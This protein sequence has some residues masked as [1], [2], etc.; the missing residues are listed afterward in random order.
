M[1]LLLLVSS[2]GLLYCSLYVVT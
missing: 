1:T 2:L